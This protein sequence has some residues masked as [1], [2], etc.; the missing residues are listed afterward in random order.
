MVEEDK[1]W[2]EETLINFSLV[3]GK[4]CPELPVCSV[5]SLSAKG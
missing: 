2:L 4:I 5:L 3:T 1:L